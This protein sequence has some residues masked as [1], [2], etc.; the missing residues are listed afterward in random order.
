MPSR[1]SLR[2]PFRER[3][4][5][6]RRLKSKDQPW[7]LSSRASFRDLF[8]ELQRVAPIH[9]C[10]NVYVAGP[11]RGRRASSGPSRHASSSKP[12]ARGAPSVGAR[13]RRRRTNSQQ[14]FTS[15]PP[16][17]LHTSHTDCE[18]GGTRFRSELQTH[19]KEPVE[20]NV[21]NGCSGGLT[22]AGRERRQAAERAD[23]APAS[24][25]SGSERK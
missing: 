3:C 14:A 8:E 17:C 5:A 11:T 7:L 25:F 9:P 4:N 18:L 20:Q 15:E 2:T 23:L 16:P 6:W 12:L 19:S 22:Q 13:V 10:I 24:R 21:A 1:E